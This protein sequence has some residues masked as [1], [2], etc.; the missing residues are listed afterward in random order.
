MHSPVELCERKDVANAA[1]LIAAFALR[2]GTAGL[3]RCA[4][5]TRPHRAYIRVTVIL[6]VPVRVAVTLVSAPESVPVKL[7]HGLVPLGSALVT[8]PPEIV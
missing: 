2:L 5:R 1:K 8:V 3:S 6:V 4:D 7:A